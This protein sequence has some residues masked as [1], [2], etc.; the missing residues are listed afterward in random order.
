MD[1]DEEREKF[2]Q[3]IAA[4]KH[5]VDEMTKRIHYLEAVQ[6]HYARE[7]AR[8]AHIKTKIYDLFVSINNQ[9][10]VISSLDYALSLYQ[11]ETGEDQHN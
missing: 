7:L 3:Q 6:E 5:K 1:H 11:R 9:N 8:Y 2:L 10:T 4:L